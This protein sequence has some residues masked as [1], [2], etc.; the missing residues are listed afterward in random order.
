MVIPTYH[1]RIPLQLGIL[2]GFNAKYICT[3]FLFKYILE[4]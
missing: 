4:D 2:V 1:L 3:P